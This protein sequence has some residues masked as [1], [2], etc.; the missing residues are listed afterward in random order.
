MP[1]TDLLCFF[2]A[3][4]CFS[5]RRGK[6]RT[7]AGSYGSSSPDG[8]EKTANQQIFCHRREK[9][10]PSFFA[11]RGPKNK[12]RRLRTAEGRRT[13]GVTDFEESA[14]AGRTGLEPATSGVTGQCSNQLNY[15]PTL[16]LARGVANFQSACKS[17][18]P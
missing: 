10:V 8:Q 2:Q 17:R 18:T 1:G 4:E 6:P 11:P 14:M 5:G 12:A 9:I 7:N 15:R 13:N 16:A 3:Q